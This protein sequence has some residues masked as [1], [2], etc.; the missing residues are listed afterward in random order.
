[1]VKEDG[2]LILGVIV[3]EIGM[4][5]EN[6]LALACN[7]NLLIVLSRFHENGLINAVLGESCNSS[8]DGSKVTTSGGFRDSIEAKSKNQAAIGR[9]KSCR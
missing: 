7:R 9:R 5:S 1:M 8:R 4:S 6:R 2:D 3:G